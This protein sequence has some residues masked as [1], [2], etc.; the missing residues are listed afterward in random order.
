MIS[1]KHYIKEDLLKYSDDAGYHAGGLDYGEKRFASP[2]FLVWSSI[3]QDDYIAI[4]LYGSIIERIE[5]KMKDKAPKRKNVV[6]LHVSSVD[7]YDGLKKLERGRKPVSAAT[8]LDRNSWGSFLGDGVTGEAA[9]T[10]YKLRGDLAARFSGDAFTELDKN[11]KRW[12]DFYSL[13]R[14]ND[15]KFVPMHKILQNIRAK[16]K[17]FIGNLLD[18]DED[19]FRSYFNKSDKEKKQDTQIEEILRSTT[20]E[21][22]SEIVKFY[23]DLC[24]EEMSKNAELFASAFF[25]SEEKLRDAYD[26][27]LLYNFEIE[28][29]FISAESTALWLDAPGTSKEIIKKSVKRF[30]RDGVD[31]VVID[32]LDEASEVDI[33]GLPTISMDEFK[34]MI[35]E[36]LV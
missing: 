20:N 35:K 34:K 9:G 12:V 27:A 26:E 6:A 15:E 13:I 7:S 5:K 36:Y 16:T 1:F 11:G 21:E 10:I 31:Y 22:K 14:R 3:I 23:Y 8:Q 29:V 28:K 25:H 19:M 32:D 2:V 24:S 30:E 17:K 4:P 18:I 33:D